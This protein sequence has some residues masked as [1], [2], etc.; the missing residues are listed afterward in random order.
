MLWFRER[1]KHSHGTESQQ[2]SSVYLKE[3]A[4]CCGNNLFLTLKCLLIIYFQI[5][6]AT[7]G[8]Y[9]CG[10]K[11]FKYVR[12]LHVW[13]RNLNT[14]ISIQLGWGVLWL[15][16]QSGSFL[17]TK[18]LKSKNTQTLKHSIA[19]PPKHWIYLPRIQYSVCQC[20]DPRTLEIDSAEQALGI[21]C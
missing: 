14:W 11:S 6:L 16:H 21:K 13:S 19:V 18:C 9:G 1:F 10:D 7:L 15:S 17:P 8:L 5:K 3:G 20:L 4:K 12:T 2:F